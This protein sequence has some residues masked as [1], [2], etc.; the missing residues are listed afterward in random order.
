MITAMNKHISYM[1]I[2]F[3][4]ADLGFLVMKID[5]AFRKSSESEYRNLNRT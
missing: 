3:L 1:S 4:A 5:F 2:G